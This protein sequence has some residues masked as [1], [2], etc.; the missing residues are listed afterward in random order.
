MSAQST[1]GVH[2]SSE[3]LYW[4]RCDGGVRPT[5]SCGVLADSAADA[6]V[7]VAARRTVGGVSATTMAL[8]KVE[9]PFTRVEQ[10]R[11]VLLQESMDTLIRRPDEPCFAVQQEVDG[12][13]SKVFYAVCERARLNSELDAFAVRGFVPHALVVSELGARALLDNAGLLDPNHSCLVVDAS[14]QTAV[15]YRL[16]GGKTQALRLA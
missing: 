12:E 1:W 13:R 9:L 16:A 7:E 14:A 5:F 2:Q 6:P 4:V 11:A 10:V 3:G 8:R 15:V